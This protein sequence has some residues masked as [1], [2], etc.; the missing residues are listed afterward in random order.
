VCECHLV[1]IT[2]PLVHRVGDD[3]QYQ[4]VIDRNKTIDRVVDDLADNRHCCVFV[5]EKAVKVQR[6][7][8]ISYF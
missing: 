6:Q 7:G 3:L 4:R 1:N 2:Q 5:K 8:L